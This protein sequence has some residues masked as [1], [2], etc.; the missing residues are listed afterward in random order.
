MLINGHTVL[1]SSPV[2]GDA[3]RLV[4]YRLTIDPKGAYTVHMEVKESNGSSGEQFLYQ[5]EIIENANKVF[6]H[7]SN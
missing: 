6:N 7:Y 4:R 1:K 3:T 5:G 2:L